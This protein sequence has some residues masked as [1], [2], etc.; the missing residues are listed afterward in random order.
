MSEEYVTQ[1]EF[2]Q[3]KGAIGQSFGVVFEALDKMTRL[4]ATI[5]GSVGNLV[6]VEEH[7]TELLLE[8]RDNIQNLLL[9]LEPPKER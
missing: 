9:S 7:N 5:S 1:Q 6:E 4:Q 3:L 8:V 2:E